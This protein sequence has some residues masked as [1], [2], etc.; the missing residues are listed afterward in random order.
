[1][2]HKTSDFTI[3]E[4]KYVSIGPSMLHQQHQG[5]N[6]HRFHPYARLLRGV[7]TLVGNIVFR[8]GDATIQYV[9]ARFG[10]NVGNQVMS[11]Y[12]PFVD[13]L[14]EAFVNDIYNLVHSNPE[15]AAFVLGVVVL[16]FGGM[17]PSEWA[18]QIA[19]SAF[20]QVMARRSPWWARPIF[21]AA[22]Y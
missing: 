17:T 6:G 11:N 15:F 10:Y 13:E 5:N 12:R 18:Y 22:G 9:C 3:K 2:P 7:G 4:C 8:T 1:M 19:R 14:F 20:L 16:H 21:W